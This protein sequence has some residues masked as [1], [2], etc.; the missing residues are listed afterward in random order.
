METDDRLRR[1][2]SHSLRGWSRRD[3]L[4]RTGQAGALLAT[5]SGVAAFLEACG[6]GTSSGGSTSST[7][8]V[9][10]PP[11]PGVSGDVLN[12]AKKY[13]SKQLVVSY[14]PSGIGG[15]VNKQIFAQFTKDTGVKIQ[16]VVRPTS[17]S[18]VYAQ[19]QRLLTSKATTPD[20]LAIDVV[21]PT[22]FGQYLAPLDQL[23][24]MSDL[25]KLH[26]PSIIANNTVSGKLVAMPYAADFGLLYYR[27]DLLKKYGFANPPATWQELTDQATKIQAGERASSPN[28]SGMVFQGNAYEGL[29]CNALEWIVSSGG[30]VI[31]N[32]KV[33]IDTPQAQS[34]LKTV[35]GWIGKIS[36]TGVTAFGEEDSRNAFTTGQAAFLRNWPYVYSL[37]A[38]PKNSKIV[39][40]FGVV[41]LPH[42]S[43]GESAA[44]VG[45]WQYG[46]NGNSAVKELAAAYI[47]YA[48]GP[49]VEKYQAINAT[50]V[51][52]MD[53][54]AKDPDVL[55]V[56]PFLSVQTNRVTRPSQLG[57][58]YNQ[59]STF[60]FQGVNSILRGQDVSQTLKQTQQQ[61]QGL[62]GG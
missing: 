46:I 16:T 41:A 18:D 47:A 57:V 40:N 61:M 30:S 17:T 2:M 34:I 60:I 50:N 3:F 12:V 14:D 13:S 52:T 26:Y 58:K 1:E 43:G 48:S 39:G 7:V 11:A 59:G 38:D 29:T 28:F 55:K 62:I 5:G 33:T 56:E 51:P 54:V 4:R 37:A 36:P 9:N 19:Y 23:P 21:Y 45:G 42:G 32:G 25:A 27:T 35:Q 24:L 10:L 8:K 15:Q 44:T 31:Q 20:I 49:D 6:G 22:A 53:Q